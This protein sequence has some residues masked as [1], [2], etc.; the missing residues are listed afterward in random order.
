MLGNEQYLS[1]ADL[2][3]LLQIPNKIDL[4][5]EIKIIRRKRLNSAILY[6]IKVDVEVINVELVKISLKVILFSFLQEILSD[7]FQSWFYEHQHRSSKYQIFY[8]RH[9]IKQ[10]I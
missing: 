5:W 3:V 10:S 4:L 2:Y 1:I 6:T 7:L 9:D 8:V